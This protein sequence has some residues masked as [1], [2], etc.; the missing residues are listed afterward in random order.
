MFNGEQPEHSKYETIQPEWKYIYGE[1]EEQIPKD[2][3][4]PKGKPIIITTFV[5]ANLMHDVITGRSVSGIIHMLNKT[6]IEWFCKRQNQVET[7]TY[8]SEFMA[9]HHY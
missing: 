9:M 2:A 8:G 1:S 7:A 4:T 3:P 6:P 5:D